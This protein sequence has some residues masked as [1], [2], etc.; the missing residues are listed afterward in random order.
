[1]NLEIKTFEQTIHDSY[2]EE[3]KK[4]LLCI[5]NAKKFRGVLINIDVNF[6][7]PY[8]SFFTNLPYLDSNTDTKKTYVKIALKIN[9]G[10]KPFGRQLP[11]VFENH[12]LEI[13]HENDGH[14][15]T[16]HQLIDDY[17]LK[18]NTPKM[19][20]AQMANKLSNLKAKTILELYTNKAFPDKFQYWW[21]SPS[22]Y[23]GD[24][25]KDEYFSK[26]NEFIQSKFTNSSLIA[27]GEA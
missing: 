20:R 13:L 18:T 5:E 12:I 7:D 11:K 14:P 23:N 21:C 1:M 22:F 27:N 15:K 16:T 3:M 2:V 17:A 24:K 25:I 4:A 19:Q 6:N 9:D 26:I 10:P 8:S